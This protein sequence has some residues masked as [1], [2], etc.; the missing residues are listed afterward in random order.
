[1]SVLLLHVSY[2]ARQTKQTLLFPAVTA[3]EP[4]INHSAYISAAIATTRCQSAQQC[5]SYKYNGAGSFKPFCAGEA[6]GGKSP[7]CWD[8]CRQRSNFYC[9]A[10]LRN[11]NDDIVD[12]KNTSMHF[13]AHLGLHRKTY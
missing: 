5:L 8:I 7:F 2:W 9:I 12:F 3:A 1:M 11:E 13:G 4:E 6:G 10:S